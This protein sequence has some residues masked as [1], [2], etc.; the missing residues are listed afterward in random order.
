[1]T[2]GEEPT[3]FMCG[4][5]VTYVSLTGSARESDLFADG[6][7]HRFLVLQCHGHVRVLQACKGAYGYTVGCLTP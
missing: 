1:M 4:P 6:D 7:G 5:S 2:V 3:P